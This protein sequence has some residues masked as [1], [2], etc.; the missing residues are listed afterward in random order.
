MKR[1]FFTLLAI[2]ISFY[3]YSQDRGKYDGLNNN[4]GNLFRLSNEM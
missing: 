1:L 3:S 4:M 2:L